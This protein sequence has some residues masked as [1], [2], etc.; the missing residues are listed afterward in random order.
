MTYEKAK[1]TVIIFDHN[2]FM[3]ASGQ[4]SDS[5]YYYNCS[6]VEKISDNSFR[7]GVY[8]KVVKDTGAV[9]ET[10]YYFSCSTVTPSM[11]GL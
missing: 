4:G 2:E 10:G 1:A 5:Y 3:A 11:F 8:S 6:G 7:C 9:Q